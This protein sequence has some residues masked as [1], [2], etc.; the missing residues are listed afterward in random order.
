MNTLSKVSGI[1]DQRVK[2]QIYQILNDDDIRDK[3]IAKLVDELT[4]CR[5]DIK[6][7]TEKVEELERK[8]QPI[9]AIGFTIPPHKTSM[10][11]MFPNHK[12]R[13]GD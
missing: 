13:G 3:K 9:S 6:K 4:T 11:N 5:K 12:F 7:L 10:E 8:M 1:Q 2:N